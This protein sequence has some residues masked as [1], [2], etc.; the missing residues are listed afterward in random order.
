MWYALGRARFPSNLHVGDADKREGVRGGS[1]PEACT[2][3]SC[4]GQLSL[5]G[6]GKDQTG[7]QSTEIEPGE[8]LIPNVVCSGMRAN[9]IKIAC[10][11]CGQTRA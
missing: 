9:F 3:I 5:I 1:S 8:S 10:R 4:E 11:R 2:D 7:S 6:Y